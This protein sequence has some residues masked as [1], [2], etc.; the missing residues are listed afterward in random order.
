MIIPNQYHALSN[1]PAQS[2]VPVDATRAIVS[3]QPTVKMSTCNFK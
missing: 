1:M 3:F 2:V